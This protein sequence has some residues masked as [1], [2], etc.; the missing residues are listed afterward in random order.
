M[1]IIYINSNFYQVVSRIKVIFSNTLSWYTYTKMNRKWNN[2]DTLEIMHQKN[3]GTQFN[4]CSTNEN[5]INWRSYKFLYKKELLKE[6]CRQKRR[7]FC[8]AHLLCF[9][10]HSVHILYTFESWWMRNKKKIVIYTY[11]DIQ[12]FF[13]FLSFFT[14][15]LED[16]KKNNRK[17]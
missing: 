17:C 11:L 10:F 14:S 2:D 4:V 3:D 9:C 8:N 6:N 5:K 16:E 1:H 15:L 12:L 13:I 7:N